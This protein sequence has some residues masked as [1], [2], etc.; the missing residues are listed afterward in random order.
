MNET[1]ELHPKAAEAQ[2]RA[3]NARVLR[4]A[5]QSELA[6]ARANGTRFLH[7]DRMTLAYKVDKRDVIHV[8]NA[9]RHPTDK[10]DP[11]FGKLIANRRLKDKRFITLRRPKYARQPHSAK[12]FP[13]FAPTIKNF[14]KSTF[15]HPSF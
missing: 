11:H 1:T 2:R 3:R 5:E 12:N 4:E 14:L 7:L 9:V 13:S 10:D 15:G 6:R 8:A